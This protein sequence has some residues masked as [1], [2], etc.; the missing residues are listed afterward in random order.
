M[1]ASTSEAWDKTKDLA[2]QGYEYVSDKA[3]DISDKAKKYVD[4]KSPDTETVKYNAG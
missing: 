1:P 2:K 3:S 4:E